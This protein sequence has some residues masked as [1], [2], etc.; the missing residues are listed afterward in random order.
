[1]DISQIR[2]HNTKIIHSS[3]VKYDDIKCAKTNKK[4]TI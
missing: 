3:I 2:F 4:H 1:M